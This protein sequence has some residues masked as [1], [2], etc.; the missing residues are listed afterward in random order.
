M[1]DR[2][3]P[4]PGSA[5]T[6]LANA[7]LQ[8]GSVVDITVQAGTIVGVDP[9]DT[10]RQA[11]A[12][13]TDLGGWL[14]VGSMVEPHAHI[15]KALTSEEVP[16]PTGDLRGAIDAWIDA[17]GRGVFSHENTVARA[18]AALDLL[19]A[20]GVTTVRT[21]VNTTPQIGA[22]NVVAV[23][24]AANAFRGIVDVQIVAL[25]SNPLAG[26]EGAESRAALAT[27][28]EA[29][30]DLIGGCP[31]LEPDGPAVIS[32]LLAAAQQ[33]GI[34]VDLHVDETL[35]PSILTLQ[36]LARQV[37][38]TGFGYPVTASHCVSLGMQ[39]AEVQAKVA[40]EVAQAGISIV[41]LPQ[42]NLFLQGRNHPTAT[43]R[44]LTAVKAL[45]DAGVTVA[46]GADNV[47]DPF[48]LMGRSDPL[49]TASLMVMAGH[50]LPEDAYSMVSDRAR[51]ALGLEP[52]R[53]EP[54]YT[55]DLVAIDAPSVRAALADASRS[56][57]VFKAGRLT[58]SSDQT[59]AVHRH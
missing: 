15:D 58:A 10:S 16:N 6:V 35:D 23:R 54:G 28:L 20:H 5:N 31:H 59:V 27:A 13:V 37:S 55:A 41:A 9:A 47:Q 53:I 7:R 29:G 49:E 46:A 17:T 18:T 36:E 12:Q 11:G 44:G 50:Q 14:T 2:S 48:N 25:P 45:V 52:I 22:A 38:D 42:T 32:V 56:R 19:V 51:I 30:V 4:Q 43:P 57:R 3:R 1:S 39:P 34:G 24:E 8:D 26:P 40:A 33:A 21:H